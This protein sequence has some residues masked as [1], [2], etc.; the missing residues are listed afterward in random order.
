MPI[1]RLWSCCLLEINYILRM[2]RQYCGQNKGLEPY[3]CVVYPLTLSLAIELNLR[4]KC[5]N[6]GVEGLGLCLLLPP[7][8]PTSPSLPS[9]LFCYRHWLQAWS[10]A[11]FPLHLCLLSL[12]LFLSPIRSLLMPE[13]LF[14]FL[15][16]LLLLLLLPHVP[17]LEGGGGGCLYS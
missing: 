9:R 8:A 17:A 7:P 3:P 12:R 13:L 16:L 11:V 10:T 14:L 2:N 15:L 4:S 1:V 6:A 5:E